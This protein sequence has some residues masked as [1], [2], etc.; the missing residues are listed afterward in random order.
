MKHFLLS[1]LAQQCAATPPPVNETWQLTS[2][3]TFN[4]V[5]A[6]GAAYVFYGN[7]HSNLVQPLIIGEGF[8]TPGTIPAR[9][10]AAPRRAKSQAGEIGAYN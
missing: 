2:P 5:T 8:E 3:Y 1:E 4:G 7:N 9:A 10:A 6:Q